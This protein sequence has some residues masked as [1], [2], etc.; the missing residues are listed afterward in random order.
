MQ[1]SKKL[2]LLTALSIIAAASLSACTTAQTGSNVGRT[3]VRVMQEVVYGQIIKIRTVRIDG[4]NSGQGANAGLAVGGIAGATARGSNTQPGMPTIGGSVLG[5]LIGQGAESQITRSEGLE[6]IIKLTDGRTVAIV[7]E[8]GND[9]F[10][11]GQSVRVMTVNNV[12]R[13][14]PEN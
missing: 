13:V 6:M 9:K 14:V 1:P 11:V 8:A 3:E 12:S 4:T 5:S 7:Q 2:S 10:E